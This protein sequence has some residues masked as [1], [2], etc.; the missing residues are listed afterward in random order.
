M[1]ITRR[2]FL[3]NTAAAGA[4]GAAVTTPAVAEPELTPYEKAIWHMRELERLA[5]EDGA[6]EACVMVVGFLYPSPSKRT[7][8]LMIG[9]NGDLSDEDGMFGEARS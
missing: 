7:K 8:M 5:L 6:S 2:L 4:V 3:R 9:R 1:S